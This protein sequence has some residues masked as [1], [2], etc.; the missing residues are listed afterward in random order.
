HVV[1][2]TYTD[3]PKPPVAPPTLAQS[4]TTWLA[5]NWQTLALIAVGL[6]S[7]LMLRSMVRSLPLAAASSP[8]AA[9][10]PAQPRLAVHDPGDEDVEQEPVKALRAR[11]QSTGPDLKVE[12][13]DIVKDNPDAAATI[14]RAWIGEAA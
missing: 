13:R 10:Q 5:D 12:L 3:L 4:S 2:E 14:L 6:G 7:L 11:F 9:H 1:V 8:A